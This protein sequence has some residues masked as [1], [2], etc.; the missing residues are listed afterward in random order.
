M[1]PGSA[2]Y[3]LLL[4][5]FPAAFRHRFGADMA[6][7]FDDR[8]RVARAAGRRATAVF[9]TRTVVDLVIHGV[10]ERR[11]TRRHSRSRG[12]SM[13]SSMLQDLRYSLRTFR[14]RPGFTAVVLVTLALGIGANTAI[15]SV[16]EAVLLRPL[17][18]PDADR[19][20]RIYET[21]RRVDFVRGVTTPFNFDV[22][23][24]DARAF[25]NLAAMRSTPATL[26]GAGEPA[27]VTVHRVMPSF[28][29]IMGR[30]PAI[31]RPLSVED[32]ET[33]RPVVVLSH[34]LWE[35]RFESD[36]DIAGRTVVL[37][38]QAFTI[39]GVMPADFRFPVRPDLYRPLALSPASRQ[40]MGSY[41]L[42]V[43]AK[44]APGVTVEQAQ[45]EMDAIAGRLEARYPQQRADRGA[46][47]LG[48]RE[49]LT[50]RVADSLRL[51]QGVVLFVLLIACANVANL[52]IAGASARRR[53]I[54]IRA[55]MGAGRAR[56]VRQWL[57]EHVTL[58]LA[59]SA[60][61]VLL[62]IWIVRA[63]VAIAPAGL[64]P[65]GAVPGLNGT[66]LTFTFVLALATGLVAGVAPAWLYSG[67]DAI[68]AIKDSGAST[69]GTARRSQR[70]LRAGL[71]ATEVALALVLVTG[72]LLLVRSFTRLVSQ[73][74]GFETRQLLTAQ[75]T[76]P[77]ARYDSPE[78]QRSFWTTLFE[79]L[80]GL[81]GVVAAA[82]STALPFS[83]WQWQTWFELDGPAIEGSDSSAGTRTVTPGYFSS[84]GI[85]ITQ[86]RD[87][88]DADR[89]TAEPVV[90]VNEAFARQFI[91]G[92]PVGRRLRTERPGSP[93]RWATI[94]GGAASARHGRLDEGHEPE[95][96]RPL[97]Q[98]SAN[99]L[100]LA[101]RTAGEPA[102][103]APLVRDAVHT[104]DRLLPVQAVRT[105]DEAIGL[106]TARRNFDL[107]LVTIFAL[108][109]GAL[110]LAGVYG[111]MSFVAGLRLRE[112]G[113]RLALG[114]SPSQVQRLV[115]RQ[116]AVP[117]A[118]G[119]A[120][121]LVAAVLLG[122]LLKEQLFEIQP[123]DPVTL[124]AAAAGFLA[125]GLIA[126]WLPARRAARTDPT[127]ILGREV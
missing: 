120:A 51:L 106:T 53:E 67:R 95:I 72:S 99:L 74:P 93:A 108:L 85:P 9:W 111:V 50:E 125:V 117:V 12:A 57:T 73:D 6:E 31:G 110:A 17:P 98:S 124:A 63:L 28:F 70:W 66:V 84:L 102:A 96:Y 33:E 109:A 58:A 39:V 7:A 80:D 104:I 41:Y 119:I 76:L 36:P 77:A 81:P 34:A 4:V 75:V 27:R 23:E 83:N 42:G 3:R 55:A 37:D 91:S 115:V 65:D 97:Q 82:G 52:G 116:G 1:K 127:V 40:A 32:A 64:L 88:T 78:A 121:G 100:I 2:F 89:S 118:I 49:D 30:A 123:D 10:A 105:M 24:R 68:E 90:V 92:N 103:V 48:L 5:V 43:V 62:A 112:A 21:N 26:T 15:F 101:I 56:L 22:W 69:A 44:L 16:V 19:I 87:F 126:S 38:D 46:A 25:L 45:A 47:V 35:S 107:R 29:E 114:A 61:G 113:I 94:V 79:R 20:V 122:D 60:L 8:R 54:S 86:G 14:R 71:V 13:L 11:A 18:Y 59:G